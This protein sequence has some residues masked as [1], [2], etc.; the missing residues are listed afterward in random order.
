MSLLAN[1]KKKRNE[2]NAAITDNLKGGNSSDKKDYTDQRFWKMQLTDAIGSALIRILPNPSGEMPWVEVQKYSFRGPGGWY[3]Q[4]SRR[5]INEKDPVY[6]YNNQQWNDVGTEEAKEGCRG[7]KIQKKFIA[8]IL[9]EKDVANP[10]N[11]GKVFLWEF[12]PQIMNMITALSNPEKDELGDTK[13]PVFVWDYEEGCSLAYKATQKMKSADG[14]WVPTYEK[15]EFKKPT[16]LCGGDEDKI[17][18][19]LGKCY[20]LS[21]FVDPKNF[22][23]YEEL[24]KNLYRA[25]G[26][27]GSSKKAQEQEDSLEE[28]E[29]VANQSS[30]KPP[31]VKKAE[32]VDDEDDSE[33]LEYFNS[34]LS[35]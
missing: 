16:P 32:K 9:V 10:E 7:R 30:K 20:D 2:I 1:L 22:K 21:E 35:D 31:I 23:S 8:N 5:T 18:E 14:K 11:N 13:E 17:E 3:I 27:A 19:L 12:G 29:Q 34:L 26:I 25:L 6:D 28:F 24:Q 15:S 33:S 4:N